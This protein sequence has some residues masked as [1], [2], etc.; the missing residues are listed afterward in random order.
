MLC[1]WNK[2]HWKR[3]SIQISFTVMHFFVL[4]WC[5]INEFEEGRIM[6]DFASTC[7][8]RRPELS[9]FNTLFSCNYQV[10]CTILA[11]LLHYFLLAL[12]CWMLCEG[13]LHYILL[14]KVFGGGAED[15]VKY[16][17]LFGWGKL[18]CYCL[19]LHSNT[20]MQTTHKLEQS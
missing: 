20:N 8:V 13:V 18:T 15:K 16:F 3:T 4:T 1:V 5:I 2:V 14:V 12:F 10:G 7:T 11:A 19:F 9:L 17:Y 6:T